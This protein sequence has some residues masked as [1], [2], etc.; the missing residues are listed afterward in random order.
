MVMLDC[1]IYKKA[2]RIRIYI[3]DQLIDEF[4]L[5][6]NNKQLSNTAEHVLAPVSNT[7]LI[8]S[9]KDA[10]LRFYE[11]DLSSFSDTLNLKIYVDNNDSNYCNGFLSKSTLIQI[12]ECYFFP[13]N[14]RVMEKINLI[15]S[16]RLLSKNYAWFRKE[17]NQIL[18]FN[19]HIEWRA[20]NGQIFTKCDFY[21]G[22][23]GYFQ[24]KFVKKYKIFIPKLL[25]PY[26][27][28]IAKI[29]VNYFY[30]KY[31]EYAYQRNSN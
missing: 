18:P 15:N 8:K 21:I 23:S 3:C 10:P 28:H 1:E 7:D 5:E 16:K 27:G 31:I 20:D 11:L 13:L 14:K 4:I 12:R 6:K 2:P 26:R 9:F 29:R 24:C 25:H 22:G 19:P 30:N 17:K